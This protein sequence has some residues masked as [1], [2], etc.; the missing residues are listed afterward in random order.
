MPLELGSWILYGLA[1]AWGLATADAI[2]KRTFTQFSPYGMSLLRLLYTVPLLSLGWWWVQV[3]ELSWPFFLTVAAALP[4]E[5]AA[6]LAYMRALQLAP[7]SLCAPM[8]AFTPV[9]LIGSGWLILGETLSLW[10]ILGISCIAGGSYLL[11]LQE[12]RRGWLAPL[13]GLWHTA[14]PRWMLAAALLY[15]F[16]SALGKKAV[17]YSSPAFFGLFY[18]TAFGLLLA[19]GAPWTTIR[20]G[21]LLHCRP[22]WGVAMGAA[23]AVSIMSHFYGIS[24]APAAYL[25][26]VKRTSLL[27]SVLYGGLWLAEGHLVSRLAGALVMFIGVVLI[28]LGGN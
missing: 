23:M 12:W 3:P 18:P 24:L 15:A 16:T 11:Q 22:W 21:E 6:N 7:L 28:T 4:L 2:I 9:F 13:T 17:L 19:A 27:F 5:T 20:L 1:S 25:I 8:L 14:G 10:G 26:A